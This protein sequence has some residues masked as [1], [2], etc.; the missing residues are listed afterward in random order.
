MKRVACVLLLLCLIPVCAFAID[1]DEFNAFA[2]VLGASELNMEE[3]K[4]SG[5][6]TGF[7]KDDCKIYFDEID[8]KLDGIYVDGQGDSFLAYCCAALHLFDPDGQT[9]INH[10]QLL[11][12]YLMA[13]KTDNYQ[14]GQTQNGYYFFMEKQDGGFFFMIGEQ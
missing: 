13:H 4:T 5:I 10:G 6:H 3:S 8:G 9:S 14:T 7:M 2:S 1:I 12:M 11:T